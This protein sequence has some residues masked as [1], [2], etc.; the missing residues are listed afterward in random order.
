MNINELQ[1]APEPVKR[2][3][4]AEGRKRGEKLKIRLPKS[5][6]ASVERLSIPRNIAM[7]IKVERAKRLE[8]EGSKGEVGSSLDLSDSEIKL[9]FNV[10]DEAIRMI[11][12]G[13]LSTK[14]T[15]KY[16]VQKW[17]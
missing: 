4:K 2:K 9:F 13:K 16:P 11:R 7:V 1:L 10:R 15:W 17:K 6:K 3:K 5:L 14:Q 12:E 8:R